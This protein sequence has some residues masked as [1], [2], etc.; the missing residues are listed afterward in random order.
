MNIGGCVKA[1]VDHL[2]LGPRLTCASLGVS[3][4][5]RFRRIGDVLARHWR[6]MLFGLR[7]FTVFAAPSHFSGLQIALWLPFGG[8]NASL[9][10]LLRLIPRILQRIFIWVILLILHDQTPGTLGHR[11]GL[12]GRHLISGEV[13]NGWW[14]DLRCCADNAEEPGVRVSCENIKPSATFNIV[15]LF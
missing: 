10:L 7:T 14:V 11:C 5:S 9:P 12:I 13:S 2:G 1:A 15:Y 8:F 4:S 3:V 6:L